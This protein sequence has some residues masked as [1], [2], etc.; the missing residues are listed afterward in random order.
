MLLAPKLKKG[1]TIGIFSPS[2]PITTEA[3]DRYERAKAFLTDK[4][5]RLVEGSLTG[6]S[7]FYRSGTIAERAAEFNA[8]VR[9]SEVTCII[10]TIG[11]MVTNSM[12]PYV[13][14][15]QLRRTPKIVMGYSDMTALLLGIYAQ[16]GLVTYYGPAVVASFGEFAP[17][18]DLSFD[19]FWP[20]V[21][22][23]VPPPHTLPTPAFWT[24]EMI[25]WQE[26]IR[27]K[28]QAPNELLT[29]CGGQA[30]GR[31]IGGN[32]NTMA[33][34]W[35]SPYMPEIRQGDILLIEDSLKDIA[36]VERSFSLLKV[37]GVFDRIGGLIL[38]K[39][40]QFDDLGTGRRPYEV[41][42]EVLDGAPDFPLLAEFDCA[43]TH[44]MLT[45]PLG[46]Q[47]M[48]DA[49]AQTVTLASPWIG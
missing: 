49:T 28:V 47:V 15:K 26:Q 6:Q 33:G 1:D 37:N 34:F 23:A 45:M 3:P 39:H 44:P 10:S 43:H 9:N 12:L 38:G 24:D 32:L 41:L 21:S 4:G 48:L 2:K 35:G 7:D 22:G 18:A 29:I 27:S 30:Q 5:F 13:D 8:L 19:Y 14:Y 36:T 17:F 46:C 31:V 11:G 42:L 40:E 16:T 25:P 20:L